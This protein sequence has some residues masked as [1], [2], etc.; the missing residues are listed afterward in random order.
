MYTCSQQACPRQRRIPLP[1]GGLALRRG[2]G[3]PVRRRCKAGAKQ[4]QWLVNPVNRH[5][6]ACP[7]GSATIT[8]KGVNQ[9]QRRRSCSLDRPHGRPPAGGPV[10][11]CGRRA[12]EAA[13][14]PDLPR[15]AAARHQGR[16]WR[17]AF[18]TRLY[19]WLYTW[20]S[21][22][23]WPSSPRRG[24][25]P[26]IAFETPRS[27]QSLRR[28]PWFTPGLHLVYTWFTRC[29]ENRGS[30]TT[31]GL[32]L[33]CAWFT[34]GL[35]AAER[36]ERDWWFSHAELQTRASNSLKSRGSNHPRQAIS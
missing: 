8:R 22:G 14:D 28:Y 33:V 32:R 26:R 23:S 25:A 16:G 27:E 9:V 30:A 6:A 20:L 31:P 17:A 24:P 11:R 1:R 19:T 7:R 3:P 10:G 29:G 21:V 15:P 34:P 18:Y 13:R 2:F 5:S 12:V 36:T 4:A 35:H